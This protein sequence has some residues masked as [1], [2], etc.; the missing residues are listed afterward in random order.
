MALMSVKWDWGKAEVNIAE[1]KD[2]RVAY[3]D[4]IL[5]LLMWLILMSCGEYHAIKSYGAL[6]TL[7]ARSL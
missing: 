2:I 6:I 1:T 5:Y 3:L 7:S 4:G